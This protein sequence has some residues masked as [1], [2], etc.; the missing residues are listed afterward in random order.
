MRVALITPH[1][2][3][4]VRGNAVTVH[5]IESW[6]KKLG[7]SLSVFSLDEISPDEMI[8]Q[9]T[10]GG[11]GICHAFHASYGGAV[12]LKIME[13]AGIPYVITLTGSD[14][15]EALYD[16]RR[17][18]TLSALKGASAVAAFHDNIATRLITAVDGLAGRVTVIHQGVERHDVLPDN[19]SCEF[20]FL[21]PAGLRPVKDVIFPL[22]PLSKLYVKH[23]EI[24]LLIVG[25]ALDES[26]AAQLSERLADFPFAYYQGA[27]DSLSM[28]EL[29]R[30]SS[31]VLNTS[32]FEGGMANSLLEAMA[33]RR[34][35]LASDI[36]GNRSLITNGVTGLLYHDASD[37]SDKA[38]LLLS[39]F[40]LRQR[41][42]DAGHRM[43]IENHSPQKEAEAYLGLYREIVSA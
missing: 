19:C 7:C 29:Y 27:V 21:L 33:W 20:R 5:R 12:A 43:A 1:Y 22:R 2:L 39:N 13:T 15:Y 30:S 40:E 38:E 42:A 36:E 24:R 34:A 6:L 3:P 4:A 32:R 31:V 8:T 26:Y 28:G 18:K 11:Y 35:V 17:E 25:P 37:F 10:S 9:V 23:P 41:L 16:S 14:L